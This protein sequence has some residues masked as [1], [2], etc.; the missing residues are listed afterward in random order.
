MSVDQAMKMAKLNLTKSK[1][2]MGKT[3][4]IP[5]PNW[6]IPTKKDRE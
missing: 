2:M 5:S 3:R 4:I 6:V 1:A